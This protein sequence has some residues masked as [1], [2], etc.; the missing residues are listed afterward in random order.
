M[1]ARR[2]FFQDIYRHRAKQFDRLVAR[3]DAQG[4]LFGALSEITP[5]SGLDV[6][7]FGAGTGRLTR[8]LSVAVERIFAFD[9]E[10]AM[11]KQ[12]DAAMR[13]SG[14]TNWRLALGDNG[15][16]P[17]ASNCADLVI[18][19]WSFA[20]AV[21]WYPDDW[22]ART[23]AMLAEMARILKPGGMAILIETLGTGR[24]RPQP[25]DK[26]ARL[27][28]HWRDGHGFE[29]RWIRTDYQFAS[30]EEADELTRFFFGDALADECLDTGSVILPECTGI[31]WKRVPWQ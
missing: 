16:M 19:G 1:S 23:D 14:M 12:A 11:L 24:R 6:V 20:H 21:G 28:R 7:E 22:L 25:T 3:E 27:Y 15:R 5:L 13:A 10:I 30:P 29:S 2:D 31:W 4:N 17:V 18:E 9:I 8:L 26:L